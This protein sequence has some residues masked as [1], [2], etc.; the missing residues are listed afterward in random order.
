MLAALDI[1]DAFLSVD[2]QQPTIVTCELASGDVEEFAL[3]KVWPGQRDGSLLWYQADVFFGRAFGYRIIPVVPVFA[4]VSRL[5]VFDA[6][7]CG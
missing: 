3:G 6:F 2:Q 5:Q 1:G 4:E 7:A